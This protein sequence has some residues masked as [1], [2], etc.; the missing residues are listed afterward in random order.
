MLALWGQQCSGQP[1]PHWHAWPTNTRILCL[2]HLELA[3]AGRTLTGIFTAAGLARVLL[4]LCSQLLWRHIQAIKDCLQDLHDRAML[5]TCPCAQLLEL[6]LYL[7]K[8]C[9]GLLLAAPVHLQIAPH[10]VQCLQLLLGQAKVG[11][12]HLCQAVPDAGD[13]DAQLLLQAGH[14]LHPPEA[15]LPADLIDQLLPLV[16][17]VRQAGHHVSSLSK[18]TYVGGPYELHCV[19]DK[20]R[21][22]LQAEL[23]AAV[24]LY[25]VPECLRRSN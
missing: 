4:H 16:D 19:V 18:V 14:A 12:R 21:E 17:V 11:H 3:A 8:M 23:I 25:S 10:P 20:L 2:T 15:P 7:H 9:K 24:E 22:L 5:R 1:T 13:D 6:P